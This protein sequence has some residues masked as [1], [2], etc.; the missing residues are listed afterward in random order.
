LTSEQ[1]GDIEVRRQ[2]GT[3]DHKVVEDIVYVNS[4]PDGRYA[5]FI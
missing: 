1:C 4:L 5:L 3:D 2:D